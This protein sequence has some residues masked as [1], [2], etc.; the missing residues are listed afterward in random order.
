MGDDVTLERLK[1]RVQAEGFGPLNDVL[2]PILDEGWGLAREG[3]DTLR[4]LTMEHP[5]VAIYAAFQT[6]FLLGRVS[7]YYAHR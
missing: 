6:G 3:I 1:R 4:R 2:D 7:R 5:W